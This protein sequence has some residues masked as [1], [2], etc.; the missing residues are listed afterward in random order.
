VQWCARPSKPLGP[1]RQGRDVCPRRH[2]AVSAGFL[3]NGGYSLLGRPMPRKM[4]PQGKMP[5]L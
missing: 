2:D 5:D 1:R 3:P 4:S